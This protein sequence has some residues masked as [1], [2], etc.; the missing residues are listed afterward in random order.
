MKIWSLLSNNDSGI[1]CSLHNSREAAETD[2]MECVQ[3]Y[4]EDYPFIDFDRDYQ[5]IIDA[6]ESE[7]TFIDSYAIQEHNYE[8]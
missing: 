5:S 3:S 4:A 7:N 6:L 8:P 1:T 2:R